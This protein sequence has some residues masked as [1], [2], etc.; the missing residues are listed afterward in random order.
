[1]LSVTEMSAYLIIIIIAAQ[2]TAQ[3]KIDK[4][5]KL[6]STHFYPFAQKPPVDGFAPNLAQPYGSPM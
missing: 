1:M 4:Y 5:S 2:K 6:A 3:N